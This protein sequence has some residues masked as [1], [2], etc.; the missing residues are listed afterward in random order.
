MSNETIQKMEYTRNSSDSMDESLWL[1]ASVMHVK[2]V[3][4]KIEVIIPISII[5][6]FN[7]YYPLNNAIHVNPQFDLTYR[8]SSWLRMSARE[9]VQTTTDKPIKLC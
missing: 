9:C 6:D 4:L 3:T 2:A 7:L 5:S 1:Q 8:I